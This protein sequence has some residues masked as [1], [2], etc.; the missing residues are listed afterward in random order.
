M[1]RLTSAG[2]TSVV[3]LLAVTF[4]TQA[5]TDKP[6]TGQPQSA[7][8]QTTPTEKEPR[9]GTRIRGSVVTEGGRPVSNAS[10]MVFPVNIASNVQSAITSLLRPVTS[11][12]DGKFELTS[13]RPGAYTISA[14]S[15]GYVLPD[16]DSKVYRPGDTATLTLIKGGVITGKVTNLSG[17]PLVGALVRAIKV[18]DVDDKAMR[19]RGNLGSQI[20]ESMEMLLGPYRTD[21]RGMYRIYGLSPGYYQVAAG[22]RSGQGM[23]LGGGNAYDGD[24]PTYHPSST[25]ETAAEVTVRAGEEAT[26]ID[27]RYREN[28]GHSLGGTVSVSSGPAPQ[29]ISVLLTRANSGVV[30]ATTVILAGRDHYGFD[31][32]LDGEYVVTAMGSSGNMA[33][34]AGSEGITASVSQSRNVTVK[35]ADVSGIN[36][37]IEPLASIAGR[38]ALEPLQDPKQKATCKDLRSVPIEGIVVST[39][40]EN[41]ETAP[42]PISGPLGAF[43]DTTPNEKGE[44]I[45]GLLRPGTHHLDLQLPAAH[46]YVKAITLLQADPNTRPIDVA[47]IGVKLK[48]GDKVKGLAVTIG[49]GAAAVEGKVVIGP[50]NKPPSTKMRVHLI[51]AEPEAADQVLRYFEADVIADGN[52]ALTNLAPG[53]Y[54]LIARET[55]EEEKGETDHKPLAWDAGART[56]LRFEGEA[57]KRDIEL[58]QC[59]MVSDYRLKYVPLTK[60][61]KP[62]A[63]KAAQ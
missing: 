18:R 62:P 50:D 47:K 20:S 40:D 3:L 8:R 60:A 33:M 46:L 57:S 1:E 9:S 14:S 16:Q 52:F 53:K 21:D 31:T 30:E 45:I 58:T 15:P 49:E 23:S 44:F 13:L 63:K 27:I 38:L 11:D 26:N 48:P 5:Q 19:V 61:S 36:L 55:S 6:P 54:W 24:A 22:G 43:K 25:I 37:V 2:R 39:R 32:L 4:G 51:P 29:A 41:K 28:R 7:Q 10:I 59:Q 56:A 35:G 34:A 42:D 12:A 17:S